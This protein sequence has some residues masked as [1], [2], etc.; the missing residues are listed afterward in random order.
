[1]LI[2]EV[3]PT[4]ERRYDESPLDGQ[5]FWRQIHCSE[6]FSI[7]WPRDNLRSGDDRLRKGNGMM[8]YRQ[9]FG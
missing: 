3:V 2:P 9:D 6:L 1:M 5:M 4:D 8:I 7:S